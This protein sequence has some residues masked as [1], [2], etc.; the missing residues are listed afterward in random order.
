M[1]TAV[2][3][4]MCMRVFV[5]VSI[6]AWIETYRQTDGHPF[7]YHKQWARQSSPAKVNYPALQHMAHTPAKKRHP[8][9]IQQKV[10]SRQELR[11]L[12]RTR[13]AGDTNNGFFPLSNT[14]TGAG[15]GLARTAQ[16]RR[17]HSER[18]NQNTDLC[19]LPAPVVH[20][21]F[22]R[23]THTNSSQLQPKFP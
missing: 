14:H 6:C 13:P 10:V 17:A 15:T 9:I 19:Q 23:Q 4:F 11:H 21:H 12:A 20:Y 2:V 16:T 5:S 18:T 1:S 7:A 3:I 22:N 8:A